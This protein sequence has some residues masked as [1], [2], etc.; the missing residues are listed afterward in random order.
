M[1]V[2]TY[3]GASGT[4]NPVKI[5]GAGATFWHWFSDVFLTSIS[6]VVWR[7]F[8]APKP[9]K[10]DPKS[11]RNSI[12]AL[13]FF[14]TCFALDVGAIFGSSKPEKHWFY[15]GKTMIFTKSAFANEAA[16]SIDFRVVLQPKIHEKAPQ[17]CTCKRYRN[18]LPIFMEF[19]KFPLHFELQNT[20]PSH[21]KIDSGSFWRQSGIDLVL[22]GRI[23]MDSERLGLDFSL[24]WRL[25]SSGSSVAFANNR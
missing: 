11:I 7:H 15:N 2:L 5:M 12:F 14:R 24:I 19:H 9:P 18:F 1:Y 23:W 17:F 4:R 13:P 22:Q 25:F 16:K 6:E 20:S 8:G 10:I 3:C 21:L